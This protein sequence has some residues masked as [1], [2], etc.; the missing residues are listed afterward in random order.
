MKNKRP[1]NVDN[2]TSINNK[3]FIAWSVIL[4]MLS[5]YSVF[6]KLSVNIR[7]QK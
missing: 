2:L 7:E 3:I 1:F 6:N 4:T 5:G